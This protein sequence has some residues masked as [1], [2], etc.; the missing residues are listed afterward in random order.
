MKEYQRGG[1]LRNNTSPFMIS[2]DKYARKSNEK[3]ISPKIKMTSSS[4]LVV[5]QAKS[6]VVREKTKKRKPQFK[7]Y[8]EKQTRR[9]EERPKK[10][11]KI[12]KLNSDVFWTLLGNR[13]SILSPE[14]FREAMPSQLSL[15]DT[16]PTQTAVENIL[17]RG[18]THITYF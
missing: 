6:E 8:S 15:F 17:S 16:L 14:T 7:H 18:A 1:G 9:E 5:E 3:K 12:V 2:I 11:K 13:I 4:E 10:R